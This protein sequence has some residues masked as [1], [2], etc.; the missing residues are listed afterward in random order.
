MDSIG[1]EFQQERERRNLSRQEV[2]DATRITVQNLEAIEEDRFDFFPNRV[3][4]R[5]FLRDYANFLGLD[6]ATLLERYELERGEAVE[7][8]VLV[9]EVGTSPK[10]RWR[11]FAYSVLI[12]GIVAGL[13][14]IGFFSWRLYDES[15]ESAKPAGSADNAPRVETSAIPREPAPSE[16]TPQQPEV[17]PGSTSTSTAV[18]PPAQ[19]APAQP[20]APQPSQPTPSDRVTVRVTAL[21][22]VWIGVKVDGQRKLWITVPAGTT[23]TFQGLRKI[24]IRAGRAN[25]VQIEQNGKKSLLGPQGV[26]KTNVYVIPKAAAP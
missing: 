6:S 13:V 8:P 17:A 15:Q 24:Q 23:Q 18:S 7:A 9:P 25:A 26:P 11:T 1:G 14:G 2:A 3:Y 12:V 4:A 16:P 19:P 20:P 21:S 5:A 22:Q 10:R